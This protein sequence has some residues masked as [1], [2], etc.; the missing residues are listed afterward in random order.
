MRHWPQK[1]SFALGISIGTGG[2]IFQL[3]VTNSRPM[4]EMGFIVE[5]TGEFFDGDIR[6]GF[7]ISRAFQLKKITSPIINEKFV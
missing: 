6:F 4:I 7:N 1:D 2:Y 3:L 5:T